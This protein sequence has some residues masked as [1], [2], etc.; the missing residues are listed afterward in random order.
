M[1]KK[2]SRRTGNRRLLKLA[3]LLLADAKNKK[4]I[5]FDIGTVARVADPTKKEV[6]LNCG[7]TACAMGLAAI[8]GAFKKQGL[9]AKFSNESYEDNSLWCAWNGRIRDYDRTAMSLF[10]I[11]QDQANY[12]F[13]PWTYHYD[14]KTGARG[15]KEVVRR[16]HRV[17]E[18][19][20]IPK[21]PS[22]W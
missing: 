13:S 6:P 5:K 8:S 7:T 22:I 21:D 16:I 3:A 19:K 1:A 12:L 10:G 14:K 4:G 9:T 17:V 18:G 11:T 20:P 2:V 15:E